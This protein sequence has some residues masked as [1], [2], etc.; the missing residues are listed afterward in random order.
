MLVQYAIKIIASETGIGVTRGGG[1]PAG[2]VH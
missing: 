1:T 2:Q